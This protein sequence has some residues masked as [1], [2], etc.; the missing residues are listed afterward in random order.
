MEYVIKADSEV[1]KIEDLPFGHE[2]NGRKELGVNQRYFIREERP[3]Y[4][5]MGEF[6]F[7]RFRR[8]FWR[9][10]VAKMKAGGIQILA[11]YVFWIHHE[12]REGEWDFTG[13]RN[14]KEFLA[15]CREEKMPV[16]LRIGPWAHGE[17]RNGGLP[18]WLLQIPGIR[19]RTNDAVYLSYAEKL[20]G[21]IY[22]QAEG[23]LWKD[24]GCII[25][26]QIENEYGHCGGLTGGDGREHML[27]LK[28]LAVK[29]GFDVPFY[30]ATGWGGGIVV[31]GEMLPVLGAYCG[32]P[33]DQG[34]RR[35]PLNAN[36]IF[37]HFKDDGN[38]GTDLQIQKESG[39]SYDTE[40]Y[41]YLTAEL[42]GGLQPTSHRREYVREQDTLSLAVGKLGSGAN[43]LGYYMYH[44][45]TNPEGKYSTLQE[46]RETGYLNDLPVYTYD[47][48]APIGEYGRISE[49]YYALRP[50]HMLLQQFGDRIADSG[51]QIPEC[52]AAAPQD[53]ESPR[54][55]LRHNESTG[56]GFLC[57]NQYQRH[58]VLKE[59]E[60]V[61]EVETD[62]KKYRFP[63]FHLKDGFCGIFPYHF[64][65]GSGILETA[66]AQPL[67]A[68][69]DTLVCCTD[70]EPV[71]IMES[72]KIDILTLT[73]E[74]ARHSYLF[75]EKL[76][77]AKGCLY[78]KSGR[79]Y[80]GSR[81]N[82]NEVLI[83]PRKN[84]IRYDCEM[85]ETSVRIA[86][87]VTTAEYREYSIEVESKP[88]E[89]LQDIWLEI[90]FTGDKA[91]CYLT[92]KLAAD[93]FYTGKTWNISLAY[94]GFPKEMTMRI[95]PVKE[96]VYYEVEPEGEYG[97]GE[98][99][100]VPEYLFEVRD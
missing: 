53:I 92:G 14:L 73:M 85:I 88:G 15:V 44:G 42:G 47:F 29:T 72:G 33:W 21:K 71:Y 50:L 87:T 12:E 55:S 69:G 16:W 36:Y 31:E 74:Q 30:T 26:I 7:S 51:A 80:L 23:Q 65:F 45:G 22:E 83:Y 70:E 67:C 2:K 25:G 39:F 59:Q 17:C 75:R 28:Q 79:L 5:T 57:I 52:S 1:E 56:G 91:E 43:L 32:A 54:V 93:W 11:T 64:A 37:S 77:I 99:R 35:L 40:A 20:Y 10:E 48:Q 34:I 66:N 95:Y 38:I 89:H 4:P 6:H 61:F 58:A 94:Y 84:L 41:P 27:T 60:A 8:E 96:G 78:E 49:T 9:D 81:D 46:S 86:E 24:G 100:A 19:V 62:G 18:D 90:P 82:E 13:D 63:E 3:W 97:M 98:I 76:Y 68:L